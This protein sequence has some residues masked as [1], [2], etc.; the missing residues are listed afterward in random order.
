MYA[1]ISKNTIVLVVFLRES[2]RKSR[3]SGGVGVQLDLHREIGKMYLK[4][5]DEAK[6][7]RSVHIFGMD[8]VSLA[9]SMRGLEV[10]GAD[11]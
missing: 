5:N 11:M 7:E 6:R 4:V 1:I 10:L 2:D 3:L 8:T 9:I